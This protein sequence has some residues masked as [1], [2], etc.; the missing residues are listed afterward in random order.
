MSQA[1]LKIFQ[2]KIGIMNMM[3]LMIVTV[4]Y[5]LHGAIMV[6]VPYIH[7][8]LGT[9]SHAPRLSVLQRK[10]CERHWVKV[11][12]SRRPI[13]WYEPHYIVNLSSLKSQYIT[14]STRKNNNKMEMPRYH[15]F[16]TNTDP[17]S[18][19]IA[20][21]KMVESIR[22]LCCGYGCYRGSAKE[23]IDV[24][25]W[26]KRSTRNILFALDGRSLGF[27]CNCKLINSTLRTEEK[28]YLGDVFV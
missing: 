27:Y 24:I 10:A 28:Y 1:L 26:W 12:E 17:T 20:W 18:L 4:M 14:L 11:T 9:R 5:C 16:D 15:A 21:K 2:P 7:F 3:T 23:G 13:K 22:E 8:G 19:G 25:L 6:A